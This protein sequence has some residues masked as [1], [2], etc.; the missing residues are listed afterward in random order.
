MKMSE[1]EKRLIEL[2][3]KLESQKCKNDVLF[4]ATCMLWGEEAIK[5]EYGLVGKDATLFNG[6]DAVPVSA[7]VAV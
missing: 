3:R 5:A 2:H 6:T 4:A 7:R 1:Q